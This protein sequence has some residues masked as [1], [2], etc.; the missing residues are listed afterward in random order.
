MDRKLWREVINILIIK[1]IRILINEVSYKVS[2]EVLFS[3]RILL[4]NDFV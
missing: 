2:I 4:K 3:P 1:I